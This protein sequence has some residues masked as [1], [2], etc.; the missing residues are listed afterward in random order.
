MA[1]KPLQATSKGGGDFEI[2]PEGNHGAYLVA[3]VDLGTQKV[4]FAGTA[5]E[6]HRLY[7]C[8]EL[9]DCPMSGM[10][11]VNHLIGREFTFSL[12]TK[13]GLADVL[14]KWRGK[15]YQ[16][17]ETLDLH[18]LF[19][20]PCL[21][22]VSH[23]ES[24]AGNTYAKFQGVGKVPSGMTVKPAQRHPLFWEIETGNLADL[25]WLPWSFSEGQ[26]LSLAD[27]AQKAPEWQARHGTTRHTSRAAVPAAAA[28]APEEVYQEDP[29]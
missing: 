19:G 15:A 25:E 17:G 16:D 29:F 8:W 6:Q 24:S 27:I 4:T 14:G 28:A 5:K 9:T 10:K 11:G 13:S 1:L 20:V 12:H 22:Q 3:I 18:K 26:R 23:L 2:P 7:L 21:V